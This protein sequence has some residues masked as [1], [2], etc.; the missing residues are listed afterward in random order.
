MFRVMR[1]KDG[2]FCLEISGT[3]ETIT[4]HTGTTAFIYCSKQLAGA[5]A[6]AIEQE[7]LDD[8]LRELTQC[9]LS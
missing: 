8:G 1:T 6:S 5:L 7:L 4:D 2:G 3:V 9:N